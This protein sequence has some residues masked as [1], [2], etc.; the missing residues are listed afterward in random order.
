MYYERRKGKYFGDGL[1]E[2]ERISLLRIF[3]GYFSH[4][5]HKA[6]AVVVVA[7]KRKRVFE[8]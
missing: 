8:A 1:E 3:S 5:P 6:H 7:E 4:K 2:Y